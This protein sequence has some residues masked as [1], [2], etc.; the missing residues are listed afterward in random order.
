M[1]CSCWM[2]VIDGSKVE[3]TLI[4]TH[5]EESKLGSFFIIIVVKEYLTSQSF[6]DHF[7]NAKS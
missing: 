1:L 3:I 4:V 6:H 7:A 5:D 2:S